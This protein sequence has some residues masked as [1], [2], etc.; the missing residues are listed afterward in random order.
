MQGHRAHYERPL[1]RTPFTQQHHR[2]DKL[3]RALEHIRQQ[4]VGKVYSALIKL[5]LLEE[6]ELLEFFCRHSK[7][8]NISL[9]EVE[10]DPEA[11]KLLTS[12][13]AQKI[14][15]IPYRQEEKD[16]VNLLYLAMADPT[17]QDAIDDIAFRSGCQPLIY[18]AT[19]SQVKKA[20]DTFY[21]TGIGVGSYLDE[22]QDEGMEAY[23]GED[24][25]LD[26]TDAAKAA[27]DAPVVKFVNGN[28][29]RRDQQK[30]Q[31]YPYRTVRESPQV[32]FRVDGT[33]TRSR[34]LL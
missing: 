7:K 24:E 10:V 30:S 31:R 33:C 32:R 5:D 15:A 29:E 23:T 18:V 12:D 13:L 1:G 22:F 6:D 3:E 27:E 11:L 4:G 25:M 28:I 26:F 14:M 34:S 20:L 21:D 19:E 9:D 2:R 17:D 8:P 16:G